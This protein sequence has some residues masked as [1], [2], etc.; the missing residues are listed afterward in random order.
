MPNGLGQRGQHWH[1]YSVNDTEDD[2]HIFVLVDM[3][4]PVFNGA[5]TLKL[6]GTGYKNGFWL[7]SK[8]F[9]GS[10]Y[11]NKYMPK[12]SNVLAGPLYSLLP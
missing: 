9:P 11:Y 3:Q 5:C 7:V 12:G 8:L 1:I 10:L 2:M 4:F 6:F